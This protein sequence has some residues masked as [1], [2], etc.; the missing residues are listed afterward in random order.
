MVEYVWLLETNIS[1]LATSSLM[2]K[3]VKKYFIPN[4][5]NE[6]KPH[7]IRKSSLAMLSF[8]AIFIFF[9]GV[10][11]IAIIRNTDLLSAVISRTVIDLA[12]TNRG[13]GALAILTPNPILE[14]AA[15][16]KANDMAEKGYFAHTSPE[17]KTPWYWFKSAGYTFMY[18]GENLAV[19]FTDS[20]EVDKAWMN[21]PG[22][23]ANILNGKFTE[24]GVAT[25][26]GMYQ[27]RQTTFVVQMFGKPVP[28]VDI[29]IKKVAVAPTKPFAS[30]TD[31]KATTTILGASSETSMTAPLSVVVQERSSLDASAPTTTTQT[32]VLGQAFAEGEET[33]DLIANP[34]LVS[35][36]TLQNTA[37]KP[38]FIERTLA[39]PKKT[40][41]VLYLSLAGFIILSLLLA[42]GIEFK[43]QHPKN[44][45]A[46]TILLFIIVLLM[47][48]YRSVLFGQ[49]IVL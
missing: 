12:N 19:N 3:F 45:L 7:I 11:N 46:G 44:V 33:K 43:K 22:H 16:E 35:D 25:A 42:I 39:T 30:S 48:F 49:V 26:E 15:Q 4:E 6:F 37:Q 8:L 47:V 34:Q 23:R 20:N 14:R 36:Q 2:K 24:I 38:T 1:Q 13:K 28:A 21:S 41:G 31:L 17:G 10:L 29:P 40:V 27:G 5:G 9:A 18:A 32:L